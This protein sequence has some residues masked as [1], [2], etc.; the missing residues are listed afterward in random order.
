MA[1]FSW[2]PHLTKLLMASRLIEAP[3]GRIMKNFNVGAGDGRVGGKV[4]FPGFFL[5]FPG[6]D[7]DYRQVGL[8]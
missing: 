8:E 6:L 4:A 2:F 1:L 5:T 3:G 7:L